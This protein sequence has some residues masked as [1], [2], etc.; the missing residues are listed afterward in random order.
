MLNNFIKSLAT[1]PFAYG[2][3]R[4]DRAIGNGTGWRKD[5]FAGS[6]DITFSCTSCTVRNGHRVTLPPKSLPT[7][8]AKPRRRGGA[9]GKF[10]FG[11]W[12]EGQDNSKRALRALRESQLALRPPIVLGQN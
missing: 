11:V 2:A 3:Q 1:P 6:Y 10:D 9:V 4:E 5:K 8:I 12:K 7:T